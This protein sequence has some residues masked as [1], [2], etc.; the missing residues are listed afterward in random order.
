MCAIS[1]TNSAGS[2]QPGPITARPSPAKA[3]S[4]SGLRAMVFIELGTKPIRSRTGSRSAAKAASASSGSGAT[5]GTAQP[6]ST[7]TARM[8]PAEAALI[9]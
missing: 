9:L 3:R 8:K 4:S 7:A 6:S 2:E 5:W 1:C